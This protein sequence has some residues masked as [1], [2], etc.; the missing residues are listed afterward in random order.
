MEKRA[1]L[2][3][4]EYQVLMN[5]Q[6]VNSGKTPKYDFTSTVDTDWQDEVFNYDAPIVN[7]Q[8]T[9]E[10]GNEK[11]SY[12]I[13]FGYFSQ[14]GIVGGNF[15]RSNYKRWT[16]RDNNVYKL[17]DAKKERNFLHTA[18]LGTNISYSNIE[19]KDIGTNSEFGS[20]LGNTIYL[21]PLLSV[22]ASDADLETSLYK[23]ANVYT[24]PRTG[25][26]VDKDRW[27][28]DGN[29]RV[30]SIAGDDYNEIVNPLAELTLPGQKNTTDKFVTNAWVE[31]GIWD[32]LKFKTTI[33]ADL[34]FWGYNYYGYEYYLGKT[35]NSTHS[36]VKAEKN[37]GVTW[38]ID[39]VLTYDKTFGSHSITLLAGQSASRNWYERIGAENYYLPK[40]DPD[41]AWIDYAEGIRT[42]RNGWGSKNPDHAISSLFGR[43]SYNY[44][45][46]YM[47]E[48]TIRRDGSSNFGPENR[49][50]I[51]P[52]VSFGWN[53]SN[54]AFMQNTQDWLSVLKL[55]ASWGKNGNESIE[56]FRYTTLI[57]SGN[58]YPFGIDTNQTI[59][60]GVKPNGI[61][62]PYLKWEES[63]QTNIG[64]DARFLRGALSLSMDWFEKKTSGMLMNV[65]LPQYV[66]DNVPIGNVGDMKNSG[67]ELDL[68]YR[69]NVS[70]L[71]VNLNANATYLKNEL[72]KLGNAEGW[73]NYDSYK[74]V[75]TISRGENG[76]PFPYFYGRKTNGIFQNEAEVSNYTWTDPETGATQLIQPNA[77]P[78]DVRFVD[79]NNDGKIDDDD[80]TDIGNGTPDW[81]FGLNIGLEWRGFDLSALIYSTVGNDIYDATR[82]TD[83]PYVNLPAYMLD[84]WCGEGTSNT[85]PRISEANS[86]GNWLSSDLYI[87]DGSFVRLKNLQFGYTLP[88]NIT[89]KALIS[90]LR[91]Y[92]AGE[93]LLT[94]TKYR[95]FDPEISSGGT[96]LGID[97]G[98]YPQARTISVGF[99]LG[100]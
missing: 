17:M 94:F 14:D 93:N 65:P 50:A 41:K 78:G 79:M 63:I 8:V 10:G 51:F 45:E 70:D 84:R 40:I 95:G 11:V 1:V 85:V 87:Q 37:R 74:D 69:F 55:R 43:A 18:N 5:E 32:N 64:V 15:D 24:D 75:G 100:F 2:N 22:Y 23:N 33:G 7:H 76:Y 96:S 38:Q 80:R 3:A 6:A 12:F 77:K 21:S 31:L 58:N 88:V 30:Y 13:S 68:G 99:N 83:L 34:A 98:I 54:E 62:N 16:I 67:V 89:K 86:N 82:R 46:R 71:K 35:N 92:I 52:S 72:I 36:W 49:Y 25:E 97:R 48:F 19:S 73:S 20:P 44:A 27:I 66:G 91:L 53:I 61:P 4:H 26:V 90:K 81:T 56:A 29:G 47:A 28:R 59:A 9:V 39:N 60:T 42:D 57:N